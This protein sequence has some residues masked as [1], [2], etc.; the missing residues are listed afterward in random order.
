MS[1]N[2]VCTLALSTQ[3][4]TQKQSK[5]LSREENVVYETECYSAL[6]KEFLPLVT[7]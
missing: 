2:G 7:M 4:K 3:A 1:Q 6:W 5:R